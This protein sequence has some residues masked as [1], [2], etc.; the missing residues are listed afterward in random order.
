MK[1]RGQAYRGQFSGEQRG[2]GRW[3]VNL[4]EQIEATQSKETVSFWNLGWRISW[5]IDDYKSFI[6]Q[7]VLKTVA[8]SIT[9]TCNFLYTITWNLTFTSPEQYTWLKYLISIFFLKIL[10]EKEWNWWQRFTFLLL[11]PS[12]SKRRKS[13]NCQ[14]GS[15][16][17]CQSF[18][19]GQKDSPTNSS[20]L[21]RFWKAPHEESQVWPL[22]PYQSLG[23]DQLS[24]WD[25]FNKQLF[26]QVSIE[27]F[28]DLEKC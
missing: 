28:T 3:T 20:A 19:A 22:K 25:A 21:S 2:W 23:S 12:S 24:P 4:E 1:V 27:N 18:N 26:M 14:C 15:P 9:T 11:Q 5:G 7:N 10:V 8:T 16:W 17:V 6:W 13:S